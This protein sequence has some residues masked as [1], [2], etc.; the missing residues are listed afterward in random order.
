MLVIK[1]LIWDKVNVTHIA[2]HNVTPKEVVEVCFGIPVVQ[3]G[4]NGRLLVF[5]L[6]K[7][8]RMI[9]I[10][11]EPK[12]EE[13]AYYVVTARPTAKKERRIYQQEKGGGKT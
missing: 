12:Y 1:R 13:G 3:K 5:G 9:T 11:I 4:H 6:T 8:D 10:V 7:R 2:H